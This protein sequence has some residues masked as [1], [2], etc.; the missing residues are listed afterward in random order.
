MQVRVHWSGEEIVD[1]ANWDTDVVQVMKHEAID[2]IQSSST[3][4]LESEVVRD[5]AVP[6]IDFAA[7]KCESNRP[8]KVLPVRTT[9]NGWWAGDCWFHE[10]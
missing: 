5:M 3:V 7:P 10:E 6:V 1:P 9:L 8:S 2:D 4:V